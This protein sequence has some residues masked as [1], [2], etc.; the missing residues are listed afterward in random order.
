MELRSSVIVVMSLDCNGAMVR[1]AFARPSSFECL[2]RPQVYESRDRLGDRLRRRL[3]Y[4]L[5]NTIYI[6]CRI[7]GMN[8]FSMNKI[9]F[10]IIAVGDERI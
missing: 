8:V 1:S 4:K 5:S 9:R 7:E 10:D 2:L 6:D 3:R